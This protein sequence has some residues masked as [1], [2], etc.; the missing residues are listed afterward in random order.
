MAAIVAGLMSCSGVNVAP[1]SGEL[2]DAATYSVIL[3]GSKTIDDPVVLAIIDPED[4]EY[5]AVMKASEYDFVVYK[6]LS[7]EQAESRAGALLNI[8]KCRGEAVKSSN[9]VIL[10]KS[11]KPIAYEFKPVYP[12]EKYGTGDVLKINYKLDEREKK[13]YITP[14]PKPGINRG[15]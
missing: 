2:S 1:S 6:G 3:Y 12:P 9:A 13:L 5:E 15:L 4:D 11:K 14:T 10:P 7:R 8:C